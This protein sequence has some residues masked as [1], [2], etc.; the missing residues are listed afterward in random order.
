MW[1]ESE[2]IGEKKRDMWREEKKEREKQIYEQVQERET[3]NESEWVGKGR[4]ETLRERK[5]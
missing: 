4:E 3:W 1:K 5:K 2:R